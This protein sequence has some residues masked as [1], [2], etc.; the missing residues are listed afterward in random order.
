MA[1][2]HLATCPATMKCCA[3]VAIILSLASA[4]TGFAPRHASL[5]RPRIQPLV[6]DHAGRPVTR[7]AAEPDGGPAVDPNEVDME[8]LKAQRKSKDM[9]E[10]D[11]RDAELSGLRARIKA[12]ADEQQLEEAAVWT[13]ELLSTKAPDAEGGPPEMTAAMSNIASMLG[14]DRIDVVE[15]V[16]E[17]DLYDDPLEG[18]PLPQALFE[19]AK[20]IEWP[21]TGKVIRSIGIVYAAIIGMSGFVLIV[22]KGLVAVLGQI[23]V[24]GKNTMLQ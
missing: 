9:A 3:S 5:V 2:R 20:N 1:V 23:F 6:G 11:E 17:V 4:V 7:R 16:Q 10:F 21:T 8:E 15:E 14:D 13:P 24:F 22:D 19:E 12:M 18:V